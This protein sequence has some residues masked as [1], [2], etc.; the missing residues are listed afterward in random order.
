MLVWMTWYTDDSVT[1]IHDDADAVSLSVLFVMNNVLSD[2]THPND[3]P[4]PLPLPL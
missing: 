4:L 3:L 2:G 1:T